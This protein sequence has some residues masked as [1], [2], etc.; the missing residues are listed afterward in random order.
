MD[1]S[2]RLEGA[3]LI[4]I[5]DPSALAIPM[6][7]P[8]SVVQRPPTSSPKKVPITIENARFAGSNGSAATSSVDS[9]VGSEAPCAL[10]DSGE[11]SPL[12]TQEEYQ[13]EN[14][15]Q[16]R[17]RRPHVRVCGVTLR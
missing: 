12:V 1:V 3:K 7:T 2:W 8:T 17:L 5:S 13:P 15:P 10:G 9:A 4:A 11:S 16:P 6:P 14:P